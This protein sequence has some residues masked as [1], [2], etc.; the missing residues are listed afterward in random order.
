VRRKQDS[1][2]FNGEEHE[3]ITKVEPCA[4]NEMDFECDLGYVR[5]DGQ[6]PC[7]EA[8]YMEKFNTE[9]R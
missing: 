9:E 5:T 1:K 8:P 3:L 4:C 2:C 6:G 7:L